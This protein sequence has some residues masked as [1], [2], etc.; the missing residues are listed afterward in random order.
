MN[1]LRWE[2][3]AGGLRRRAK[4]T[5]EGGSIKGERTEEDGVLIGNVKVIVRKRGR[6]RESIRKTKLSL[7]EG[8][9]KRNIR[10]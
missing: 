2:N 8:K 1:R 3:K 7:G 9:E 5:K 4:K 6:A 10:K